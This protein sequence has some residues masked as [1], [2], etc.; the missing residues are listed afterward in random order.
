MNDSKSNEDITQLNFEHQRLWDYFSFH[1]NQRVKTIH[2][3][4][5]ILGLISSG[6]AIIFAKAGIHNAK[7][8]ACEIIKS[9]QTT[10][11]GMSA[12]QSATAFSTL[13]K[14]CWSTD[15][16]ANCSNDVMIANFLPSL[17]HIMLGL[18]ILLVLFSFI[19]WK[20]EQRN[21]TLIGIARSKL[22]QLESTEVY[23]YKIFTDVE[24]DA[25]LHKPWRYQNCIAMIYLTGAGIG[26][27]MTAYS[28]CKIICNI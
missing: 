12:D 9:N 27:I 7:V 13:K 26:I 24:K 10:E 1:A 3:Y 28:L 19:F 8:K 23:K 17:I 4:L 18:G 20:I 6:F 2:L 22:I 25:D 11:H 15:F 5:V 14:Y 16:Q 21:H